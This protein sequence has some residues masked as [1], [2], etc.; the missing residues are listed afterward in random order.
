[1]RWSSWL[2]SLVVFLVAASAHADTRRLAVVVG[3]N[4]GAGEQAPLH[5][6]ETDAGKVARVLTEL[7]GVDPADLFLL[8]GRDR[9]TLE[10]TL[11]LARERVAAWH[12]RPGT[13]VVLVFYFSGHSD[14]EALE[15]GRERLTFGDLRR[16]LGST[17]AEVRLAVVDSCKSGALLAQKGGAPGTGFQIRLTDDLSSAGEA[18]LTSSAADEAALESRDIGGSFFT[19]HLVSGLRGAADSSGDGMVTLTEAYQYAYDHTI[20][21]TSATIA[22]PQHPAYDYQLSGQGE[23]VLTELE[24]PSALL[25]MPKGFERLLVVDLARD[26][27]IAE[28]ATDARPRL[29]VPPGRYA[30]R[31]WRGGQGF[32]GDVTVKVGET[33]Y[34]G[35]N[36]LTAMTGSNTR[37]KGDASAPATVATS[38]PPSQPSTGPSTTQQILNGGQ[39]V[40]NHANPMIDRARRSFSF[41]PEVGGGMVVAPSPQSADGVFSFGLTLHLYEQQIFSIDAFTEELQTWA[42]E[43]VARQLVELGPRASQLTGAELKQLKDDALAEARRELMVALREGFYGKFDPMPDPIFVGGLEGAYLPR[44]DAWQI[45]GGFGVGVGPVTFGP[46]MVVHLDDRSGFAVG[47]ELGLNVL[48][49]GGPRPLGLEFFLRFDFFVNNRDHLPDQG[50][51]GV[52]VMFDLI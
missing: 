24:R 3:N 20:A 27:V 5:F 49:G 48:V 36:E 40:L 29:A 41:G 14:G 6:A 1:M 42:M 51:L 25:E 44:S 19:N 18:L 16:W 8:Q 23:L 38:T 43:K 30:V 15:I 13:R 52:R 31:A 22:G 35:W 21:T 45:R 34:V 11:R 33:R 12:R 7:G 50:T 28:L 9:T 4:A 46:T 26:Q 2:V 37:A 39:M 47:P 32:A 10:S 17:G